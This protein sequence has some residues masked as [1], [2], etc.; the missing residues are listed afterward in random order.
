MPQAKNHTKA[1]P[2]SLTKVAKPKTANL[3]TTEQHVEHSINSFTMSM[4]SLGAALGD[5]HLTP[6]LAST[7]HDAV[8]DYDKALTDFD[9]LARQRVLDFVL[10]KG[11]KTTD[12]GSMELDLGNG[13]VQPLLVQRSGTDPKKFEAMIRA[14]QLSV[15]DNMDAEVKYKFNENKAA[16]LIALGKM[17]IEELDT[18]AYEVSY[19]VNKTK[20]AKDE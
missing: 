8:S 4:Q 5:K 3:A 18:C 19:R 17:T 6:A 13:R 7:I 16:A 9:K 12:A 10:T 15:A 2:S 20:G 1:A 11:V 14:K